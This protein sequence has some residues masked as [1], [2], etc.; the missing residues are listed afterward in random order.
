[1]KLLFDTS[2]LIASL[3]EAHPAHLTTYPWLLRV[4]EGQDQGLLS[5]HSLAEL[6]SKLTRIPFTSGVLSAEKVQR[7]FET[8][9]IGVFQIVSF[10]DEDYI[11]IIDH[12]A[13]R[14]LVGGIIFDALICYAGIKTNVDQ[15]L[16]LNAKHFRQIYPESAHLIVEL[17]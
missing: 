10:S 9:I 15:I 16:A 14:N 13:K 12:L 17:I 8:D 7:I 1:M 11:K 2:T 6:Y 4:K 3:V 5:L